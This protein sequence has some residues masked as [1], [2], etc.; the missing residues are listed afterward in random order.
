MIARLLAQF[1]RQLF[2]ERQLCAVL[3]RLSKPT[4]RHDESARVLTFRRILQILG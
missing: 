3:D 1:G 2:G 4:S